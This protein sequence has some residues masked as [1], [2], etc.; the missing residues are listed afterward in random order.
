[1]N[2]RAFLSPVRRI[3]AALTL[4]PGLL[5]SAACGPAAL[6]TGSTFRTL[7]IGGASRRVV[8]L[9]DAD[10]VRDVALTPA[11][12]WAA[13]DRGVL[14]FAREGED[15]PRR[16]TRA[17]GL[18]SDDV[19]AVA[20][21]SGESVIVATATGLAVID[22][23]ALNTALPPAPV[24]EVVDLAA[25]ADGTVF[26]CG[27]G[28]LARL[29]DGAWQGFGEPFACTTLALDGDA[30][31]VGST[32]GVLRVEGDDVVREH[33]QTRGIP[34]PYVAALAPLAN[35]RLLALHRGPGGTLLG[36]W[37]GTHWYGY[38]LADFAPAIDG[39]TA[40]AGG[41]L[42]FAGGRSYAVSAGADRGD[43]VPLL[44]VRADVEHHGVRTY[45][46]RLVPAGSVPAP[47]G[48]A[49]PARAPSRF[50]APEAGR[51]TVDAPPLAIAPL[52]A[53]SLPEGAY[54]GRSVDGTL[55]LADRNRGLVVLGSDGT[56]RVYRT[57]D[58]V[59]AT[60]FQVATD[61][62]QR[63]WALSRRGD[64]LRLDDEGTLRR[65]ALP[66]GVNP[67]AIATGDGGAYLCARVGDTAT[68][69]I[70]RAEGD[71]WRQVIERALSGVTQ[72]ITALP[73]LGVAPDGA[74]W[75]GLEIEREG[76]SGGT[77]MRGAVMLA[78]ETEAIVYHHRGATPTDGQ[79]AT[80]LPDEVTAVDFT[81]AGAWFPT[82]SG[83]VRVGNSQA[84]VF[85]EARGVRGEVVTDL[86]T[87]PGERVWVAAAEGLGVYADGTFD[88][89]Q[90]ATAQQARPTAVAV[91]R[92]G[93]LWAAGPRGAVFSDGTS[94]QR[95]TAA[96]GLPTDDIR[97]IDVDGNDRVFLLTEDAVLLLLPQPSAASR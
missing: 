48:P 50:E 28:G 32:Q 22:G 55:V 77:R 47:S 68:V 12:V 82:I 43:A 2:H 10:T 92:A 85:G 97:D 45:R 44:A 37:D 60:D 69:R 20:V 93:H 16:Y 13:T 24:G 29:K 95:L 75:L 57:L 78:R 66:E 65:V 39:L 34:E 64:L 58:L 67:Q 11:R 35:G 15:A 38:T 76:G 23:D 84:V 9:T 19:R 83:A 70:Y 31:W 74:F 87:A 56:P 36:Y 61:N 30:L 88:F 53:I 86:A 63:T 73:F 25:R 3:A 6:Q 54:A 94:W 52:V 72:R 91:D 7:A 40:H 89:R 4:A 80:P 5:L 59:G 14:V 81:A 1:M 26:A 62:L 49:E 71:T 21:R 33:S 79:G 8:T 41:A 18:P 46:A 17:E 42:L 96:N 90:P 27:R 51:A